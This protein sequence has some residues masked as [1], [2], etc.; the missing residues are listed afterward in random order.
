MCCLSFCGSKI[1]SPFQN[2]DFLQFLVPQGIESLYEESSVE[3]LDLLKSALS[4]MLETHPDV[5]APVLSTWSLHL[6]GQMSSQYAQRPL[7]MRC[8]GVN[9]TIHIWMS[10]KA[11]KNLLDVTSQ[12]LHAS[13]N[14]DAF[15][16]ALLGKLHSC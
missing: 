9:E 5:W 11:I 1:R 8:Q 10:S 12:C 14:K 2:N 4:N 6:L 15:I 16:S 3:I 7:F 13:S